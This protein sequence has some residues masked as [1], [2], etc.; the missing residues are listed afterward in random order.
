MLSNLNFLTSLAI[1]R[2]SIIPASTPRF[3]RLR[4]GVARRAIFCYNLCMKKYFIKIAF[5]A[6][7]I[8]LIP[9][10]AMQFTDEV[11]WDLTDFVVA[12]G[13]LVG[14]GLSYKLLTKKMGSTSH[15]VAVGVAVVVV[16]LL[17]WMELA[18]GIFGTPFA[19]S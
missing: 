15:R 9:L 7:F 13:L 3:A 14:T 4:R 12:W 16:L 8:L 2:Q 10:L 11:V 6:T 18:V 17:I 5:I 1:N 19:G